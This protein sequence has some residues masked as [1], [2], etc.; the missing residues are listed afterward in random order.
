MV[1]STQSWRM[2]VAVV[3]EEVNRADPPNQDET[4]DNTGSPEFGPQPDWTSEVR[5]GATENYGRFRK[6]W[7]KWKSKVDSD[8]HSN[9]TQNI[10]PLAPQLTFKVCAKS[11]SSLFCSRRIIGGLRCTFFLGYAAVGLRKATRL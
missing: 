1:A 11:A 9:S 8:R 7:Y 3:G 2:D 6:S 5:R 10:H 4:T